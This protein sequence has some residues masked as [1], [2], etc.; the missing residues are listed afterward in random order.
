MN[1]GV[2]CIA[3]GEIFEPKR[4]CQLKQGLLNQFDPIFPEMKKEEIFKNYHMN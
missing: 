4:S 1:E 3:K 2:A